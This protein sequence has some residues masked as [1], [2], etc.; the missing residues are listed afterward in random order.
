M[1]S[2]ETKASFVRENFDKIA[3][4]YDRFNDWNSFFLHR[5]W[6][7]RMVRE[8]EK[9]VQG[10]IRVL[11]LCCGTGD[12]SVRLERSPRV[13]SLLSL[14]FSEKMLAVA[15]NRLQIPIQNG[16]AKVEIGDATHLSN[17]PSE[18]LD[19]VSI[20]FGLRN[21]N[22]LDKALSEILRVLKPGG[23]FA[24]LDVGKV[25]NPIIRWFANFYFF[26]IVPIFG[27]ILWGGKN[28]MFDYLPVSSL[29][30][31]DQESLKQK[32]GALGFEKVRYTNFV[33]GNAVLHIAKKPILS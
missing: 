11:D 22:H 13:E 30:Y 12:I 20:G 6:K 19:A 27:Y 5:A 17:V 18:S 26:R 28:D 10:P 33:F 29:Y 7:N 21:V 14:D 1:P 16:R 3:S 15:Q 9:E 4:K 23:V 32:L 2:Q 24:N 8:I 31:P 25:K